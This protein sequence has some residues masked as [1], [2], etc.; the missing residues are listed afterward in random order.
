MFGILSY[1][2]GQAGGQAQGGGMIFI[3]W[4]ILFFLIIYFVTILPENR[5]RKKL[6]RAI[7]NST[8]GD[9]VLT[10]GG[11]YGKVVSKKDNII[12]IEVGSG[13]KIDID[14]GHIVAVVPKNQ[15]V[16]K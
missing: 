5:R 1:I 16:K 8:K 7:E 9:T 13:V 15:E 14:K 6:M 12:T 2:V 3:F 10:A 11:I 4:I